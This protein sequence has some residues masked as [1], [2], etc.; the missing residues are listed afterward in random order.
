MVNVAIDIIPAGELIH[1]KE[2]DGAASEPLTGPRAAA[3]TKDYNLAWV[4]AGFPSTRGAH[5]EDG[6]GQY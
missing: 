1:E 4:I 2:L 3:A 5:G 6:H